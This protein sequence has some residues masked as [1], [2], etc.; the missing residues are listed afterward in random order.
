MHGD[1]ADAPCPSMRYRDR[2]FYC[3]AVELA[4]RMGEMEGKSLRLIMGIGRGCDSELAGEM[5][6]KVGG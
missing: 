6:A 1:N 2:R 3:E 4:D 5:I